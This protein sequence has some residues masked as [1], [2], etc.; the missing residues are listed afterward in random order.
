MNTTR[1]LLR[2]L[3]QSHTS[4]LGLARPDALIPRCRLWARHPPRRSASGA[5]GPGRT[6]A[7]SEIEQVREHYKR[8]NRTTA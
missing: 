1:S 4:F 7:Q 8:K 5:A 2:R 6:T 3:Q